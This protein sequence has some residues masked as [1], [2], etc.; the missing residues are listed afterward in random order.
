[1]IRARIRQ[2]SLPF[3]GYDGDFV[4]E[5][6]RGGKWTVEGD[7]SEHRGHL[8][9]I[10]ATNGYTLEAMPGEVDPVAVAVAAERTRIEPIIRADERR[11][12]IAAALQMATDADRE[13]AAAR[14][15]ELWTSC[16]IA[17]IRAAAFR[18]A[19]EVLGRDL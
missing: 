5:V 4:I 7:S 11:L 16:E 9:R 13:A 1:M 15:G 12:C 10:A 3:A 6:Y 14:S 2:W 8:E 17:T 19:A 18:G